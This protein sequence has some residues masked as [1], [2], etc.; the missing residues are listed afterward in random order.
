MVIRLRDHGIILPTNRLCIGAL[1][2]PMQRLLYH[3]DFYQ[4]YMEDEICTTSDC[5]DRNAGR[6]LIRNKYNSV[7]DHYRRNTGVDLLQVRAIIQE[8]LQ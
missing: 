5:E 7:L 4:L 1:F 2:H 6:A 3:P 8:K